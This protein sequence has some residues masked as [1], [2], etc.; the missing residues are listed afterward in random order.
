MPVAALL[1]GRIGR[2]DGRG[3]RLVLDKPLAGLGSVAEPAWPEDP[4]FAVGSGVTSGGHAR[5]WGEGLSGLGHSRAYQAYSH[6]DQASPNSQERYTIV[7]PTIGVSV[8][9]P[10]I[11]VGSAWTPRGSGPAHDVYSPQQGRAKCFGQST[12]TAF[13]RPKRS[14]NP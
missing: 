13:F 7:P 12:R 6:Q 9:F 14:V 2:H 10:E 1:V 11:S 4:T 3:R 8:G 5:W